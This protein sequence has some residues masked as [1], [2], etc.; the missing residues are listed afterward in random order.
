[1][2]DRNKNRTPIQCHIRIQL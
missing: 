2:M 1:M